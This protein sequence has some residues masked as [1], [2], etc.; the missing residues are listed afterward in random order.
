[1]KI[2]TKIVLNLKGEIVEEESFEYHGPVAECKGGGG[3]STTTT[4]IPDWQKPYLENIYG[5]AQ[6]QSTKPVQYYPGQTVS[7]FT[8]EQQVAQQATT[9][10][11]ITGSPLLGAAQ[12]ENLKT[13][14]GQYLDPNT[15]PWLAKTYETAARDV[16]NT[17]GNVTV[18][19]IRKEAGATGAWGGARQGVAEG[20]ALTGF[21]QNLADLATKIYAPAYEAERARQQTAV[22]AAPAL[23]EADYGDIAKL[24]AVGQEKQAMDQAQ[25][26]AAVKAWQ[27]Q[28]MEPWQRLGMYSNLITGDVGGTT[29]SGA[30]GK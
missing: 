27:F 23:A 22:T 12:N 4:T 28:Q 10:R 20:T 18:P 14:S 13:T 25:I 26:D 2:Y 29:T 24:A 19:G 8:P 17:F 15:N 21:S 30:S 1:M 9:T 11:A 6:G 3:S 5:L 7:G 16:A